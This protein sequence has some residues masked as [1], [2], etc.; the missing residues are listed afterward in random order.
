MS[1]HSDEI[2]KYITSLVKTLVYI[3]IS[4]LLAVI[5]FVGVMQ[6]INDITKYHTDKDLAMVS[7]YN[8][9]YLM[10]IQSYEYEGNDIILT[11][12]SGTKVRENRNAVSL[13]K[14]IK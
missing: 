6:C 12:Q 13:F 9:K 5:I 10:S 2:K 14:E 3:I 8:G 11:L 1:I 7:K 4:S